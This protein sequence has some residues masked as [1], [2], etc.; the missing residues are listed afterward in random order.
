[1]VY[2]GV[3]GGGT[4]SAFMLIDQ[5]GEVLAYDIKGGSNYLQIGKEL[6][7]DV[8][9]EGI[10]AVSKQ[11][12]INIKEID[13]AFLG[14]P[15]Y[16]ED[17]DG[18][19]LIEETVAGILLGDNYLI[20]NDVEAGWAGSLACQ[21]GINIVAGT[22]SI[23]Y[24]KDQQGK[25][26]RCG[27]WGCF[28]GDEGSAYW[29]GK[30]LINLFTKEADGRL[31]KTPIYQ[32]IRDKYEL[33]SDF[34][35]ISLV[36]DKLECKR[37]NIA[38][39]AP[40]LTQAAREGDKFAVNIFDE[41]AKELSM[42]VKSIIKS[43]DFRAGQAIPVSYSGG[44]FKAVELIL[45]PLNKYLSYENVKLIKPIMQPV[46]G[47][48]LNAIKLSGNLSDYKEIVA[49]LKEEEKSIIK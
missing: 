24:G 5:I 16:G 40:L 6:I 21:P 13:F 14:I 37:E 7:K 22:G 34:D 12:G 46:T 30:K 43:L 2:L 20:G 41:A 17:R 44:V 36:Y 29:L 28:L 47:A 1:M 19:Q 23:G 10:L 45:N 49:R 8:L 18:D 3:D 26:E 35:F 9:T 25:S 33:Q 39:M 48:A 31:E 38:G 15:C 11:A 4:K 27:G 32:I 42:L